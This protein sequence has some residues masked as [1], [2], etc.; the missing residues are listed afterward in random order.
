M[1]TKIEK[2]IAT[3]EMENAA[4]ISL[5]SS[6]IEGLTRIEEAYN[7]VSEVIKNIIAFDCGRGGSHIWVSNWNGERLMVITDSLYKK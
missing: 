4:I 6:K 7:A 5:V 1:T 3:S 2:V